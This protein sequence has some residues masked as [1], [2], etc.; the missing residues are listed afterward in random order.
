MMYFLVR[1]AS[2]ALFI[3][4]IA[5]LGND[6][7]SQHH[8]SAF[9]SNQAIE[10]SRLKLKNLKS[11]SSYSLVLNISTFQLNAPQ[12]NAK[13]QSTVAKD[14][15]Q[16]VM[17][18]MIVDDVS[19]DKL[20]DL[21]QQSVTKKNEQI[22][23][24]THSKKTIYLLLS[25]GVYYNDY[26]D[27]H[28]KNSVFT[29]N[30]IAGTDVP[31]SILQQLN[32]YDPVLNLNLDDATHAAN[33]AVL[34][35]LVS[36]VEQVMLP[37]TQKSYITY[38]GKKYFTN[39]TLFVDR[40]DTPIQLQAF[41]A[42]DN[43][44]N[45]TTEWDN[46]TPL[47]NK[48]NASH[49]VN[50][51]S[52]N[53]S[54]KIVKATAQ[55]AS[56]TI[57]VIVIHIEY[58]KS[59]YDS[60]GFDEN[61]PDICYKYP[62]YETSPTKGI[63]WKM[64][65]STN[66]FIPVWVIIS[67]KEIAHRL[68]FSSSNAAFSLKSPH[69]VVKHLAS[70]PDDEID[71]LQL[72]IAAN[73]KNKETSITPSLKGISFKNS[74]LN[75]VSYA[76]L[77]KEVTIVMMEEEND[78]IQL[79]PEDT[80]GLTPTTPVVRPGSNRVLDS[81][82]R[83]SGDDKIIFD[84]VSGDSIIIAGENGICETEAATTNVGFTSPLNID[85]NELEQTLNFFYNEYLIEWKVD[86]VVHKKAV[87]YDLDLSWQ[88]DIGYFWDG[89][90]VESPEEIIVY[91]ARNT[92]YEHNLILVEEI[93]TPDVLA[94][95]TGDLKSTIVFVTN[96]RKYQEDLR[97]NKKLEQLIYETCAHELGHMAFKLMDLV[98]I[99]NDYQNLMNWN[100]DLNVNFLR[101]FQWDIMH[102]R[103]SPDSQRAIAK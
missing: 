4:M 84:T 77:I 78:D 83:R 46:A 3:C 94:R 35:E 53:L 56:V 90:F 63:S 47:T 100:V 76:K 101:K 12:T 40:S 33:D 64:V 59:L 72:L 43:P 67:P 13:Q 85:A 32:N 103:L 27:V 41:D 20:F 57:R 55:Q 80:E 92:S 74:Q 16:Q 44:F 69:V 89:K 66:H 30:A 79:F 1:L 10:K 24:D 14:L 37:S 65:P 5:A 62:S 31:Q 73:A 98:S 52:Y 71:E 51:A 45:N 7:Y 50:R 91:K 60:Y 96:L 9:F 97:I 61:N 42:Q 81:S 39:D 25:I 54:G 70:T 34:H 23:A 87:N 28:K 19:E 68:T 21:H 2:F 36:Y 102:G 38:N 82:P 26:N 29:V 11:S 6:L 75:A 18:S 88:L 15:R 8:D 86:K 49:T 22:T 93:S 48:A 99:T 58:K 17:S 95:T